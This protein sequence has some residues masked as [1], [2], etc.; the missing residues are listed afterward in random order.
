MGDGCGLFRDFASFLG[1]DLTAGL[2]TLWLAT[3]SQDFAE[4]TLLALGSDGS[5]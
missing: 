5:F 1:S 2:R 3:F 4:I